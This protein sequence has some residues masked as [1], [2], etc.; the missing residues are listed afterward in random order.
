MVNLS[1]CMFQM[2]SFFIGLLNF[3]MLLSFICYISLHCLA[4]STVIYSIIYTYKGGALLD[5]IFTSL[6][7]KK[8]NVKSYH[9]RY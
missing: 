9:F 3:T 5:I 8:I 4:T 1:L 2:S 7:F 6:H